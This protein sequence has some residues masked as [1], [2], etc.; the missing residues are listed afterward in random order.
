MLQLHPWHRLSAKLLAGKLRSGS[1]SD[2][3]LDSYGRAYG[4][5]N[6]DRDRDSYGRAYDDGNADC[7]LDSYGRAYGDGNAD[8]DGNG[9]RHD[10]FHAITDATS[11]RTVCERGWWRPHV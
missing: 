1:K 7:D 6:A 2:P 8:R 11:L 4:D 5:G 10:Y 9:H 3:D